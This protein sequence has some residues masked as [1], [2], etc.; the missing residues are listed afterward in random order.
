MTIKTRIIAFGTAT[1]IG[2]GALT[3]AGTAGAAPLAASA[4]AQ[5]VDTNIVKVGGHRHHGHH[6]H[7]GRHG[8]GYGHRYR[9]GY[10]YYPG[11]YRPIYRDCFFKS[12]RVWD[13]YY[14]GYYVERR[15]VC[16]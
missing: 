15:K 13:P 2:L 7:H 12:V 16:R 10:V 11:A 6:G 14:G 8:H 4:A 9:P 3:A 1:I 5:T